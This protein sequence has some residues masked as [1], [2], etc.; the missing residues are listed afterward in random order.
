MR[1]ALQFTYLY[2]DFDLIEVRIEVENARF[3]G[4]ADV[5]VDTHKLS[6]V[7][8]KLKGFPTDV[9]DA[10][11]FMFGGFGSNIAGGAVHLHFFCKDLAGHPI[12]RARIEAFS[13]DLRIPSGSQIDTPEST[14]LYV[15]FE[16]AALDVFLTQLEEI[17]R[18]HKG[19]A[20]LSMGAL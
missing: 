18:I 19:S 1:P 13:V 15:D 14:V 17:E 3:R 10:R 9:L 16:P 6:E 8:A 5:Y 12:I 20:V 11:E 7:A 2:H 4:S